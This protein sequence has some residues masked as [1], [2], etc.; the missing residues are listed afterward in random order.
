MS[1]SRIFRRLGFRNLHIGYKG[2]ES[3]FVSVA[4]AHELSDA[5]KQAMAARIVAALNLTRNLPLAV[6]E[7]TDPLPAPEALAGVFRE[8]ERAEA[9]QLLVRYRDGVISDAEAANAMPMHG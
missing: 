9:A 6:L 3:G 5:E 8:S 1:N 4:Y 2:R 7:K